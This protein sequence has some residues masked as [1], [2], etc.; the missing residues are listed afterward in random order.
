VITSPPP[1][2]FA[3]TDLATGKMCTAGT[4]AKVVNGGNGV[5]DYVNISGAGIAL[6]LLAPAGSA[7]MPYDATAHGIHGIS[8]DI[9]QV[10]LPGLRVEL[11]NSGTAAQGM[12]GPDY[13]GATATYPP[14][15]VASGTDVVPF[16]N[17]APPGIITT[18]FD[19][20]TLLSIRFHVPTSIASTGPYSFCISRLTL[21]LT[22]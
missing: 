20:T 22:P 12:Y 4:V 9:D 16:T 5:P 11:P 14:S 3:P 10:P 6:D 19:P 2:T 7:A 18:P 15:P 13:W 8:F 1:G 17:V 21:R